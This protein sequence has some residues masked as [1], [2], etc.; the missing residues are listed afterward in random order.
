MMIFVPH[1]GGYIGTNVY[2][3]VPTHIKRQGRFV[4][5]QYTP[6]VQ[7]AFL[8]CKMT[9]ASSSCCKGLDAVFADSSA[10]A[11]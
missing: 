4:P 8:R 2:Q 10:S 7:Q 1:S 3:R 11:G 9:G 5:L 6:A